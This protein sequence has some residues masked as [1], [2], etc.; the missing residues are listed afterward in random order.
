MKTEAAADLLDDLGAL[1]RRTRRDSSGYWLPLLLF[2]LLV[3]AAPLAYLGN[4]QAP[5]DSYGVVGPIWHLGGLYFA[6]LELFEGF[7]VP[8]ANAVAVGLYWLVAAVV[9]AAVTF[10]WYRARAAR[11]GVQLPIGTYLGY[12]LGALAMA[13]VGIPLI[14]QWAL[15]GGMGSA[16]VS[17]AVAALAA[18]LALAILSARPWQPTVP[19]SRPRTAG[20]V[21]GVLITV[22]AAGNLAWLASTHGFATLYII[23]VGLFGLAWMERSLLCGTIA[24]LFTGAALLTN[25]YNMENVFF[26]WG[27][28]TFSPAPIAFDN[29]LL[30]GAVLVIGGAVALVLDRLT[31]RRATTVEPKP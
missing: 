19:K 9:G 25:L 12:M 8:P 28:V 24:A 30:P 16:G 11:L 22:F 7:V 31:E 29:L 6:P 26:R 2:G 1:R 27:D 21:V 13:I 14:T 17:I 5:M 18:G 23:A 4:G 3:L 10:F 15:F 20:I